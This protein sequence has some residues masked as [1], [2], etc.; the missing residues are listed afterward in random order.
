M[1][2]GRKPL[3]YK[4]GEWRYSELYDNWNFT[5]ACCFKYKTRCEICPN[6]LVCAGY[7]EEGKMHPVKKAT[8]LTYENIG[9]KGY[10]RWFTTNDTRDE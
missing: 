9:L 7:K 2:R 8:M 6:E 5:T 10:E 1:K 4:A 3:G